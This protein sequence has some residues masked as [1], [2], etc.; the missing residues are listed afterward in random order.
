MARFFKSNADA[1]TTDKMKERIEE[2]EKRRIKKREKK[3][4][5]KAEE[6][7]L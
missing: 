3:A 7:R 4:I 1:F 6:K 5:R 2:L